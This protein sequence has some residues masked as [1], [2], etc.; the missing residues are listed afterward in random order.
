[1][2]RSFLMTVL[3][4]VLATG[5]VGCQTEYFEEH[6]DEARQPPELVGERTITYNVVTDPPGAIIFLETPEGLRELGAAPLVHTARIGIL[7]QENGPYDEVIYRASMED[8]DGISN[9]HEVALRAVRGSRVDRVE[10]KFDAEVLHVIGNRHD[11]AYMSFS[12]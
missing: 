9:P 10:E 12:R 2:K 5:A 1:M 3:A 8:S 6:P 4:V 11:A 7:A